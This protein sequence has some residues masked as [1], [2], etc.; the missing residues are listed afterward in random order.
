MAIIKQ[1]AGMTSTIKTE[2]TVIVGGRL[3]KKTEKKML[4][5]ADRGNITLNSVKKVIAHGNNGNGS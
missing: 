4:I 5:D 3:V 2:Y 1:A